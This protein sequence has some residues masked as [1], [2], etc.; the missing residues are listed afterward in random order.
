MIL[1]PPST[2]ETSGV[3]SD[4]YGNYPVKEDTIVGAPS[5][6]F[7]KVPACLSKGISSLHTTVNVGGPTFGAWSVYNSTVRDPTEVSR[8]TYDMASG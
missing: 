2:E 7:R 1:K 8:V 4:T 5:R 6:Q 3:A